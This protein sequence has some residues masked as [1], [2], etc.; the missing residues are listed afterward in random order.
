MFTGIIEAVGK[1]TAVRPLGDDAA[2]VR[3]AV[4]AGS[5]D[6]ADIV[7][8]DSVA[9]NGACLTVVARS[10][11]ELAFDVSAS[12]ASTR[13]RIRASANRAVFSLLIGLSLSR[14]RGDASAGEGRPFWRER[15]YFGG[16]GRA[17]AGRRKMRN[18]R[19]EFPGPT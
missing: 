3:L 2:G 7:L 16:A 19:V 17:R 15:R 13:S 4:D 9:V 10:N 6:C 8:G 18:V 14:G 5:L 1:I 12:R 11:A